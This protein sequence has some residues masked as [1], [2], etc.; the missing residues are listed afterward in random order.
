MARR[1]KNTTVK[2]AKQAADA[3]RREAAYIKKQAQKLA[4]EQVKEMR[5]YL[6]RLRNIDLR[7]ELSPAQRS[8][9]TKV[10]KDYQELTTRP[11][12]VYK[13]KNKKRLEKV[14]SFAGREKGMTD[15]DVAFVPSPDPTAK[16]VFKGKNQ[17]PFLKTKHA[18]IG[19]LE[20]NME[21]LA[22]NPDEEIARV[23]ALAPDARQFIVLTGLYKMY[24]AGYSRETIG[25]RVLWLMERY[26]P[27]GRGYEKRGSNSHFSNWLRGL[28]TIETTNQSDLR[29]YR[30]AY[31][32]AARDTKDRKRKARRK[33]KAK[34]NI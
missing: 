10:W 12:K 32:D 18:K 29:S 14:K 33:R 16:V 25:K 19:V 15:F 24:N 22:R 6:K 21:N 7:K 17:T 20:F 13:S 11:F 1:G 31:R 5:P 4:R 3:A 30:L 26:S 34:Y 9:I 23:L 8:N 2:Q 27:G 28:E